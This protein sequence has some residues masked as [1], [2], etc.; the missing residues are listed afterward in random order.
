MYLQVLNLCCDLSNIVGCHHQI[1]PTGLWSCEKAECS[2]TP[3]K[4]PW[5]K[6]AAAS[7]RIQSTGHRCW[8]SVKY[9]CW[10]IS[11]GSGKEKNIVKDSK[12]I[13]FYLLKMQEASDCPYCS[14]VIFDSKATFDPKHLSVIKAKWL[15]DLFV[16]VYNFKNEETEFEGCSHQR[17]LVI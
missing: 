11:W 4:Y 16:I 5:E 9:R 14:W 13:T 10:W 7:D 6:A 8:S 12:I 1:G 17:V 15:S 2:E 3:E